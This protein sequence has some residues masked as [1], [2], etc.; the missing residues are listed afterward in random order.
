MKL[1]L[2]VTGTGIV[3]PIGHTALQCMHSVRSEIT[4]LA[5]QGLPDVTGQ[6]ISG[7]D[8]P[9]WSGYAGAR[10]LEV[11]ASEALRQA[12]RVANESSRE[13]V[14]GPVGII[15]GAPD[16]L[17]P[18]FCFPPPGFD[19]EEWAD[20][21]GLGEI[22]HYE[23]M[24]AGACSAQMALHRAGEL[25]NS[26]V[27]SACLIGGADSQL[28]YRVVRWHEAFFRLKC[29][30]L[31]DG[32]MPGEAASFLVLET[33]AGAAAR[34]APALAQILS[35]VVS[36]EEATILSDLPNTAV[37][38][39]SAVRAALDDAGLHSADI[40]MV[41]SDLNGESYRAREWAFT[42][43]RNAFRTDATLLHPADC[44]GD[45][46]AASD[47]S[48]LAIAGLAHA[49]G[50]AAGRPTLVFSGSEGGYRAATILGDGSATNLILQ[51]SRDVPRIFSDHFRLPE[52]VLRPPDFAETANPPRSLFD[53]LLH[54]EHRDELAALHYQRRAVLASAEVS[55]LRLLG[56]EQRMLN[57][58]DAA[59]AGGPQSMAI[60]A[61]GVKSDEEGMGFA[62]SLLIGCLPTAE[63][64][65]WLDGLDDA[66]TLV[67]VTAGLVHS[68]NSPALAVFID[69]SLASGS[70]RMK[71]MAIEVAAKHRIDVRRHILSLLN[72]ATEPVLLRQASAAAWRLEAREC[73]Q[74]LRSL[75]RHEDS[76]VRREA[77]L[78]LLFFLP[79]QTRNFARS[80]LTSGTDFAGALELCLGFAGDTSDVAALTGRVSD[81][82]TVVSA[83]TALGILGAPSSIDVLIRLLRSN[84]EGAAGAAR[85]ALVRIC[86][87]QV[88]ADEAGAASPGPTDDDS[89][90]RSEASAVEVGGLSSKWADWWMHH[91]A[92]FNAR[93]RYRRGRQFDL[94]G[95]IDEMADPESKL[96]TRELAYFELAVMSSTAMAYEPEWFVARQRA[97]IDA[98]TAK[99]RHDNS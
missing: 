16:A 77:L 26:R 34:G 6:W 43:V 3:G 32:L 90:A 37:A 46:G 95:C 31:T 81:H 73:V 12:W 70:P 89:P 60:V 63:N 91:R 23:V 24:P 61:A 87:H 76:G 39:T 82:N 17:R 14:K 96:A 47:S 27:I 40:G 92:R 10:H 30:Y 13:N 59:V 88:Q 33:V 50:W 65:A 83:I 4:R 53:W 62:G 67:G 21:F 51:V 99:L 54:E 80:Q 5:V 97:A 19:L 18:G 2:A 68:P 75:L 56:P 69:R 71:A 74:V 9:T 45:L 28:Q 7:G 41:W 78:S 29:S 48:L 25:L 35:A 44:H 55:W 52:P 22:G 64:F 1:N 66:A 93:L 85:D 72:G 38:L 57:H 79:S 8:C 49:T 58:L 94:D 20:A 42:E 11:L 86:G 15:V 84:V 36:R 98:W